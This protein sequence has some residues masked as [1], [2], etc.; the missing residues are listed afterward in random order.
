MLFM[1]LQINCQLHQNTQGFGETVTCEEVVSSTN[2]FFEPYCTAKSTTASIKPSLFNNRSSLDSQLVKF[3]DSDP[4]C[5][6]FLYNSPKNRKN[7]PII[8]KL[9]KDI[10]MYHSGYFYWPWLWLLTGLMCYLPRAYWYRCESRFMERCT[11]DMQKLCQSEDEINRKVLTLKHHLFD[12]K[13]SQIRSYYTS[14]WLCETLA[15]LN[16]VFQALVYD[17][18]LYHELFAYGW[19]YVL[20]FI[21]Y[22]YDNKAMNPG[23]LLFART[24]TCER[25]VPFRVP[26]DGSSGNLNHTVSPCVLIYNGLFEK[27]SIAL[28]KWI[29]E[30]CL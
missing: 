25:W 3:P 10:I 28:N 18:I 26:Q 19:N 24:T 1:K 11:K 29:L 15:L 14:Y 20:F 22:Y 2:R 5:A 8:D 6:L 21:D 23:Y 30:H 27:V 7:K 17:W 13:G 4:W 9:K 12:G 16:M